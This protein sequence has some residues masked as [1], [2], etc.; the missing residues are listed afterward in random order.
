SIATIL[1]SSGVSLKIIQEILGHSTLSTT[2][3]F[4]LH[5]DLSEK[6]KAFNLVSGVFSP[7]IM[8]S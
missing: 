4:Y 6:S 3:N 5:P 2:A 1:L 7:S 8:A